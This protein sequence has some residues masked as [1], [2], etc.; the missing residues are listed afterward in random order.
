MKK[1]SFILDVKEEDRLATS[2]FLDRVRKDLKGMK[3]ALKEK[4][5]TKIVLMASTI[6]N[7]IRNLGLKALTKIGQSVFD[8]ANNEKEGKLGKL[9]E[10]FS[11]LLG[12]AE[13]RLIF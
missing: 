3:E 11:N 12:R 7:S 6:N 13:V 4:D 10:E 1:K 5:F 2:L 9:L 8:A